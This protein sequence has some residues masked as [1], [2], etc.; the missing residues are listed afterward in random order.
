MRLA[1]PSIVICLLEPLVSLSWS[2]ITN[3]RL[4]CAEGKSETAHRMTGAIGV[5]RGCFIL[6]E[7]LDRCGKST[8][9]E[10]L[11]NSLRSAIGKS[12]SVTVMKF[13]ERSSSIGSLIGSYLSGEQEL[14]NTSC[15]LLFSAQRWEASEKIRKVI[16]SGNHIVC[17]RYAYSGVAF[18]AAKGSR[19]FQ[20]CKGADRGLPKPDIGER[21]NKGMRTL[22]LFFVCLPIVFSFFFW[23]YFCGG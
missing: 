6:L 21:D 23:A 16:N 17:D 12:E 2:P 1:A 14:D 9:T 10:I 22:N 18:T 4:G 5:D 15:H 3:V 7:G 13:P 20:W 11:A 8:Q 19:S